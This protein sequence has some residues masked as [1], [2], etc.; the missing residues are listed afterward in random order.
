MR[1]VSPNFS[2]ILEPNVEIKRFPDGDDY[3]C[4]P[5]VKNE[6]SLL[7][8]RLYPN[9][10]VSLM[11]AML[12]LSTLKKGG[13]PT[14]LVSPYLPYAR[15]DKIFKEGEALSA[16]I[17]CNLLAHAGAKKLV[18]IDCHFMKREGTSVYGGLEIE[19]IS[20][21]KLL[22]EHARKKAGEIEVI[23]PDIGANYLVKEFG[24]KSM[25]KKRGEY[26]SGRE[27][28]RKIESLER[29]FE[30]K[31]KNILILDDMISTGGTMLKAV[32]NVKK[33]G[34]K[35]VLCA[36]THGFFLKDSLQKLNA[37]CDSVFVTDSIPSPVSEVSIRPLLKKYL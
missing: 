29:S 7:F 36:A 33:G 20:A 3:V 8:H 16:E 11:Q 6:P 31:G 27:T 5:P 4:I 37:A 26:V 24:G 28:Y 30:V 34:A 10:D 22:I 23:S 2:D 17:I 12:M 18:T 35:K 19:S 1:I 9:Q 13:S 32:E 25:E 15:Q 21:N 14:T